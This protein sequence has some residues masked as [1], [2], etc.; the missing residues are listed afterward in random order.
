MSKHEAFPSHL[1]EMNRNL[2][3]GRAVEFNDMPVSP[4]WGKTNPFT[5]REMI[6]LEWPVQ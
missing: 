1:T 6:N 2:I 5:V 3:R 4:A